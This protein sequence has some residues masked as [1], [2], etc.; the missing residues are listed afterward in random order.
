MIKYILSDYPCLSIKQYSFTEEVYR[1]PARDISLQ[2]YLDA[3][4]LAVNN[5]ANPRSA[6]EGG[7]K[8]GYA[9]PPA[10]VESEY[11]TARHSE[12]VRVLHQ[13]CK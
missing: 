12:I 3:G 1:G 9:L 2:V 4:N 8:H 13:S 10:L 11:K 7:S 5:K 6:G